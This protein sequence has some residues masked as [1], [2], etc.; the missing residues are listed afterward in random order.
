[1]IVLSWSGTTFRQHNFFT[2]EYSIASAL[3]FRG[4]K[5]LA[6]NHS[7]AFSLSVFAPIFTYCHWILGNDWKKAIS[8]SSGRDGIFRRVH[9]VTLCYQGRNEGGQGVQF[10]WRRIT[11]GVPNHCGRRRMNFWVRR[12]VQTMSQELFVISYIA[13]ERPQVRTWGRQT[14]FLS[15]SQSNLVTPAPLFATKC[16]PV[17]FLKP[18]ISSHFPK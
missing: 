15:R 4:H 18:W 1:M 9:G 17:K 14:C 10:P 12:K 6:F 5:A 13:C 8:R 3:S 7:K 2:S 11:M 16:A